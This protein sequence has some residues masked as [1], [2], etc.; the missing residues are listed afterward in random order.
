LE[1]GKGVWKGYYPFEIDEVKPLKMFPFLDS[2]IFGML[3]KANLLNLIE[4]FIFI[5]RFKDTY[6]KIMT[7]YTQFE[8]ANLIVKRVIEEKKKQYGLVWHWQGS[9]KTLTMAFSSWKLLRNLKLKVPTIFLVVDRKDLQKQI[10][11]EEFLPIGINIEKINNSSHLANVLRWGGK[12]R[13]GKRGIFICLIQK[14]NPKKLKRYH[15]SGEINLEREN[16]VILTDESHRSQYGILANVMRGI[17]KNASI[18]GFTGTPLTKPERNTFA[19]FSPEGEPYLHRFGMLNSIQDGFTLP[20][21]YEARLH[22]LHLKEDE[23]QD[24]A[25]YEEEV[26]IELTARERQRYKKKVK[27]RIALLKKPERI[28]KVSKDIF[29]Y[30]KTKVENTQLKAMIATVDR[31]CAVLIKNELEKYMDPK[32]LE[33]VVTYPGREKSEAIRKHQETL[34]ERFGTNDFDKINSDLIYKFKTEEFPKIV[35]VSDKLLTGFDA[36]NLWTLFLYKPLKEHRLLQAIA[37]TN[38][39]YKDVKEFG[40]VVDYVGVA[41]KLENALAQFETDFKKEAKLFIKELKESEKQFD[42]TVKQLEQILEGKPLRNFEDVNNIAEF[43]I[44]NNKEKEFQEKA[45]TLRILYEMLSPSDTTYKH[46][47]F[48]K[49]IITVSITLKRYRRR[50]MRLI[51]IEKMAKKTYELIQKSVGIDNIEKIGEVDIYKELQNLKKPI[52]GFRVLGGMGRQT[53]GS[54]SDFHVN[55][56][57]DIEKIIDEMK[58]E[59]ALTK[60]VIDKIKSV[61]ERLDTRAKDK[62]E[63]GELFPVF[64]VLRNHFEDEQKNKAVSKEIVEAL[65]K[66]DLLGKE[67]FLK[68]TLRKKVR[69][70]IRDSLIRN[71]GLTEKTDEIEEKTLSNLEEEYG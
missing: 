71:F 21:R 56:R 51:E 30:F 28:E 52:Q 8:A 15:D 44:L 40:L 3:S 46:L 24:L 67:S 64:D 35:I 31:E 32:Y 61:Q 59:K 55:L 6:T 54:N 65:K 53:E 2:S 43:L 50:G 49:W 41:K 37:R 58:E 26:E 16:I 25:D 62:K 23:I 9:G 12:T 27:P 36:R 57:E 69:Q 22:G 33:V 10:I 7:W 47:E 20:I 39:P 48:Y 1:K 38:R 66:K 13:E 34:I 18:F 70:T 4:N 29:E 14:F 5:K 45:S 17:F 63:L 68:Q 42:K 11:E 19:K 60:G